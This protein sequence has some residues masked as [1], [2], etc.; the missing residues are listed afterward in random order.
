V[1]REDEVDPEHQALFAD[2]V[3]LALLGGLREN[4]RIV[5]QDPL[6]DHITRR[7]LAPASSERDELVAYITANG[8][9]LYHPL[10]TCAMGTVVAA[11]LRV[12][13]VEGLRVVD[14][15][16]MPTHVTGGP[17]APIVMIAEKAAD[18]ILDPR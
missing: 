12:L 11:R 14:A 2:S 1:S 18:M 13:G 3:G 6:A 5:E 7:F 9:G 16:V 4:L 17:N 10:G 8:H 15:S